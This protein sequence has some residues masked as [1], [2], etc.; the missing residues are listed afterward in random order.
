MADSPRILELRRRV[1]KDPASIAFA[2]LAEEYRRAQRWAEAIDTAR[3]GL[4]HHPAYVSARVTLGRALLESG[5]LEDARI[6]LEWALASAPDNLAALRAL[7]DVH[8]HAGDVDLAREVALRG[9]AL[10]PEDR[11]FRALLDA[12]RETTPP[13]AR[14]PDPAA[15]EPP[16]ATAPAPT[17]EP[18]PE[19]APDVASGPPDVPVEGPAFVP[20]FVEGSAEPPYREE[21][22]VHS[23]E[24]WL[25]ALV[26]E[27]E[28]RRAS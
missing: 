15:V 1:Q 20:R 25:Q 28:R 3:A 18:E 7:A 5:A 4:A 16:P 27:R 6:E 10:A 8:H 17:P 2:A 12:L 19:P 24:A 26:R 21:P 13:A 11:E 14:Q 22:A 9:A 23:L